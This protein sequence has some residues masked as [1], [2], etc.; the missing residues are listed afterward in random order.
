MRRSEITPTR[1]RGCQRYLRIKRFPVIIR[2][3]MTFASRSGK[4]FIRYDTRFFLL[5]RAFIRTVRPVRRGY[6][7]RALVIRRREADE[8]DVQFVI[9]IPATSRD[10][11]LSN[12]TPLR[13]DQFV[14]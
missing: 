13:V 12:F 14:A 10:C 9:M 3:I 1:P 8:V 11:R 4:H 5:S 2:S 6:Y 7:L